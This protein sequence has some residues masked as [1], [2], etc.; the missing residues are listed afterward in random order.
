LENRLHKDAK[1]KIKEEKKIDK[2][3]NREIKKIEKENNI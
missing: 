1:K 3:W 2:I